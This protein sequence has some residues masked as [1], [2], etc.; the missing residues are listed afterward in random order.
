MSATPQKPVVIATRLPSVARPR[1]E[2]SPDVAQYEQLCNDLKLL[3]RLGAISN[4]DAIVD[5]VHERAEHMSKVSRRSEKTTGR[6]ATATRSR[7][8]R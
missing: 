5:A 8:R 1:L 3:R 6:R 2:I 7:D 4:T